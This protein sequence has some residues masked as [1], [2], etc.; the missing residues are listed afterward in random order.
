[1]SSND[2]NDRK[3]KPTKIAPASVS[4]NDDE[5]PK[6]SKACKVSTTSAAASLQV[7]TP[8]ATEETTTKNAVS[9]A[10]EDEGELIK[11]IGKMIQDLAHTDNA[12]LD[13]LDLD[14]YKKDEKECQRFVTAGGCL[15]LV[16]QLKNCLDK[17]IAGIQT[18]DRVTEVYE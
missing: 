1:M 2:V 12:A 9:A 4:S 16:L 10:T 5:L 18:C 14:L 7:Y 8:V 17:A 13:A 3:R 11:F 6:E 15:A